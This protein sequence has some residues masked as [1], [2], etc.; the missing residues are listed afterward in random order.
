[1]YVCI[2]LCMYVCVCVK[3]T[4]IKKKQDKHEWTYNSY[5]VASTLPS[6]E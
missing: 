1:M 5:P 3:Q 2:Y 4:H 6:A